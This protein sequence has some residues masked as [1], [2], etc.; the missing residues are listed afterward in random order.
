MPQLTPLP[1][2]SWHELLSSKTTWLHQSLVLLVGAT[3]IVLIVGW[4]VRQRYSR[5]KRQRRTLDQHAKM[6]DWLQQKREMG[7]VEYQ[8]LIDFAKQLLVQGQQPSPTE[9]TT[10]EW[11]ERIQQWHE[12]DEKERQFLIHHFRQAEYGQY[13]PNPQ[14]PPDVHE[15]LTW[16]QKRVATQS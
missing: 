10:S 3:L 7:M 4:I 15:L 11:I 9:L 8:T 2:P 1:S 6:V 16:L 13:A 14:P 5:K 12:C